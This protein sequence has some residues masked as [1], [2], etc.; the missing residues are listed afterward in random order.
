MLI[1]GGIACEVPGCPDTKNPVSH[2]DLPWMTDGSPRQGPPVAIVLHTTSGRRGALVSAEPPPS[3]RAER[4]AH[5]QAGTARDV[6]WD[7]T[8]DLDG[9]VVQHNDPSAPCGGH[10]QARYSWHAGSVNGWT[11]GIEVVQ[12]PDMAVYEGQL[13]VMV[14]C[15]AFFCDHYAIPRRIPVDGAGK[16]WTGPIFE[17]VSTKRGGRQRRWSGVLGHCN[18]TTPDSRGPGDPG[19]HVRAALL[20][21]GFEGYDV[22]E[23]ARQKLL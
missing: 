17:V 11:L 12:R 22:T 15:V 1:L 5:Y 4:Y 9:T 16:P 2:P 20:A 18:V 7:F 19:D 13:R 14:A 6:S 23:L 8:V 3:E 10:R 21:S